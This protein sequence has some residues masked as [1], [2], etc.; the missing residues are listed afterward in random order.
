MIGSSSDR[1]PGYSGRDA[2]RPWRPV[3]H[4]C[5]RVRVLRV[6]LALE[7]D[8]CISEEERGDKNSD[9]E[10]GRVHSDGTERADRQYN[11]TEVNIGQRLTRDPSIALDTVLPANPDVLLPRKTPVL[12]VLRRCETEVTPAAAVRRRP[13]CEPRAH[14]P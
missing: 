3:R 1:V 4:L 14:R 7:L 6:G 11:D 9:Q 8:L 2:K 10:N 13:L 12:S 5:E